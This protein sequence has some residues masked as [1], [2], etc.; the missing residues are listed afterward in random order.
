LRLATTLFSSR[1]SDYINGPLKVDCK[2]VIY[3]VL[4]DVYR[5]T[6]RVVER[7]ETVRKSAFETCWH[8]V[9]HGGRSEGETGEW[10]E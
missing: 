9:T 10:S 6:V 7:G 2:R 5:A 8:T 3:C 4:N 1:I